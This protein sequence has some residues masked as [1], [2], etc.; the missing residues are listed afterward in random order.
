MKDFK[1]KKDR[2]LSVCP[3]LSRIEKYEVRTSAL[4]KINTFGE[5]AVVYNSPSIVTTV[6]SRIFVEVE[7][8]RNDFKSLLHKSKIQ[9]F[10]GSSQSL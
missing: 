10:V 4:R 1:K 2:L 9:K 5:H 7:N 3:G 6:S 8:Q